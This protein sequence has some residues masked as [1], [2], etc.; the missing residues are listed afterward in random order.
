[1]ADPELTGTIV[2]DNLPTDLSAQN[3]G[4]FELAFSLVENPTGVGTSV[5]AP[6]LLFV[7]PQLASLAPNGGPGADTQR[8]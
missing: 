7:D 2:A 8:Q 1:M 6:T 5:S 3:G 4:S